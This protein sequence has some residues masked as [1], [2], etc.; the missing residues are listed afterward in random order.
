MMFKMSLKLLVFCCFSL[1][2]VYSPQLS[3]Q[4]KDHTFYFYEGK[5]YGSEAIYSPVRVIINGGF[6]IMQISN[7]PND[8]STVNFKNGF[9]NVVFNLTHPLETIS[10][11]GW[12]RFLTREVIPTSVQLKNAQYY[13]NYKLHLIGGG[14]TYRAFVDWYRWHHYPSPRV[15]ALTSWFA[16]HFLNEIVE[17]NAYVGHNVDPIA[18]FY[19]FNT[20]GL[21]LFSFNGVARFF[22]NTLNMQDWSFM[23]GY[24]PVLNT[25]ENNGQNF[26]IKIKLPFLDRWSYFNHWG[27]NGMFGLS[28][29]RD[30]STSI[31]FA[32]GVVAKELINVENNSGV[33][34]L[35]TNLVWTAGIFYD[36]NNSL[37]TSLILAGTKGY[38]ARLNV[39]PGVL[40][41][42]KLSPGFFVNLRKD[43]QVVF[44]IHLNLLP[45]GIAVRVN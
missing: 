35:T 21:L 22:S 17:N 30:D 28:Y 10:K 34:E 7:R 24:D 32:G 29:L 25:I 37:L 18:D 9:D 39:Y 4:T 16:Y 41:F 40:K 19:I 8:L 42:G 44:G 14:F 33:R 15:W 43:N 36:L 13:P 2:L 12:E 27:V 6:G 11:F 45:V 20:A 38:K 5:P 31:S 23:P 26:I 1:N 3:G